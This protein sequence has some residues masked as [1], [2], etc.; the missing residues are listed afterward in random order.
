MKLRHSCHRV[1]K[2]LWCWIGALAVFVIEIVIHARCGIS[3]ES[4]ELEEDGQCMSEFWSRYLTV[5]E[6]ICRGGMSCVVVK[7]VMNLYAVAH[8]DEGCHNALFACQDGILRGMAL[9]AVPCFTFV[10]AL[11]SDTEGTPDWMDIYAH[12]CDIL[13]HTI[14][15]T[16]L[17]GLAY[18]LASACVSGV[19]RK[20][21]GAYFC[22]QVELEESG[23]AGGARRRDKQFYK[24]LVKPS[25]CSVIASWMAFLLAVGL[26]T[27]DQYKLLPPVGEQFLTILNAACW[28]TIAAG[29][30]EVM[31]R[32]R[33]ACFHLIA[34]IGF[35]G[36]MLFP[37]HFHDEEEEEEAESDCA[38]SKNSS[39]SEGD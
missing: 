27:L 1:A 4:L 19:L 21:L 36:L 20:V 18:D 5:I 11:L 7:V 2:P 14:I 17:F 9:W 23:I 39:S 30:I 32:H 8:S 3:K 34:F 22:C 29:V 37:E 10:V 16:A 35:S 12:L 13:C 28:F 31:R 6:G 26:W 25:L 24:Q 15:T 38:D 33:F